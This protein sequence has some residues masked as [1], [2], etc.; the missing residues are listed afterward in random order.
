MDLADL[1]NVTSSEHMSGVQ[2]GNKIFIKRFNYTA[3]LIAR[4]H[5]LNVL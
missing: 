4:D 5:T 3:S 2:E 1:R